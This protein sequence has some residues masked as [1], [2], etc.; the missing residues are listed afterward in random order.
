[1]IM[2]AHDLM[3]VIN[4]DCASHTFKF[5]DIIHSGFIDGDMIYVV[6]INYLTLCGLGDLVHEIDSMYTEKLSIITN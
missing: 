5:N 2:V 3:G 1:M 4:M 6:S